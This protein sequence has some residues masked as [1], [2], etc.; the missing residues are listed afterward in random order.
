M[1]SEVDYKDVD[2]DIVGLYL[3]TVWQEGCAMDEG[4]YHLLPKR[5]LVSKL[6]RDVIIGCIF[7][8]KI[9]HLQLM[10]FLTKFKITSSFFL[11]ALW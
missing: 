6:K 4:I 11:G 1:R 2:M 8:C 5:K 3:A 10:P 7:Y 9:L